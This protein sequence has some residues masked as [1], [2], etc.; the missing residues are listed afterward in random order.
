[1]RV[2]GRNHIYVACF[3]KLGI[4]LSAIPGSLAESAWHAGVDKTPSCGKQT[5]LAAQPDPWVVGPLK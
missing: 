4:H 3:V 1:M 5:R 2:V